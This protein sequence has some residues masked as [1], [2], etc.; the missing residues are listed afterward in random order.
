M[1]C[2][3]FSQL[4]VSLKTPV[5]QSFLRLQRTRHKLSLHE[6]EIRGSDVDSVNSSSD[7]FAYLYISG[8]EITLDQK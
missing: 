7:C 1:A 3:H 5:E 2:T 8:S 4:T 6:E